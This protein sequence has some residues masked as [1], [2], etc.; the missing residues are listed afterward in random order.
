MLHPSRRNV[1]VEVTAGLLADLRAA[2][3]G[4]THNAGKYIDRLGVMAEAD[5]ILSRIWNPQHD[6]RSLCKD[7]EHEYHR[8]FDGYE[9]MAAVGCKYCKCWTFVEA[10]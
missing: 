7:C 3:G 10:E 6:Q 8:H 2:A 1:E 9:D 5:R 4:Y